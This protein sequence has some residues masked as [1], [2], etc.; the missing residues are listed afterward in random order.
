MYTGP[1]QSHIAAATIEPMCSAV[2]VNPEST[3]QRALLPYR[4]E[5]AVSLLDSQLARY[6]QINCEFKM[7]Q[8][9]FTTV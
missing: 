5:L 7:A 2:C 1:G 9:V 3:L 6:W 8:L 4:V